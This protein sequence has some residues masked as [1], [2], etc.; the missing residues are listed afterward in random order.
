MK[1][2]SKNSNGHTYT[3]N[4]AKQLNSL[5]RYPKPGCIERLLRQ[6]FADTIADFELQVACREDRLCVKIPA[7]PFLQNTLAGVYRRRPRLQRSPE[8]ERRRV[9]CCQQAEEGTAF[10][11]EVRRTGYLHCVG[12]YTAICEPDPQHTVRHKNWRL[13]LLKCF[14]QSVRS[15]IVCILLCDE[16]A[17]PLLKFSCRQL[18][19][20]RHEMRVE[21]R[22][23]RRK[24]AEIPRSM[25]RQQKH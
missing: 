14:T 21:P 9:V 5:H 20:R 6:L 19:L 8:Q 25:A 15:S 3:L 22:T 13:P 24:H 4:N 1:F 2:T 10:L 23:Q 16:V 12:G 11:V 17:I 7:K 18:R